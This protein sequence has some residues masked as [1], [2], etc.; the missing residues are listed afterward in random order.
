MK[1]MMKSLKECDNC[2]KPKLIWKNY[3]GKKW[4]KHCWS[5]HSSNVKQKPTVKTASI[6]PR[7]SKKEKLDNIYSQQRKL[8]LTYKPMCEAH[9]PGICTQVS[10]DVHHKKGR[11]G[12]NYLDTTTW[13]SV[14]RACHDYIETN[15][16]FAKEE[17][18][19]QNRK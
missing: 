3:G 5:C 2:N 7:S 15:P 17:G 9:I 18:F 11:L 16:L 14:C 13:L 19:S 8:F 12:G 6:R 4:C 10:T 1:N